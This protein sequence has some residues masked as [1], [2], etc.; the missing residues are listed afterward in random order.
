[1]STERPKAPPGTGNPAGDVSIKERSTVKK[2]RNHKVLM[3]NDDYT[4]QVFVVHV[5]QKFFKKN[6]TEATQ[7]MLTVHHTGVG[8]CGVFPREIA[9]AKAAQVTDY[10]RAH[11]FPL[12]ITS[13]PE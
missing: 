7:I 4:T 2:P 13:E 1:M 8:V 11:G 12:K 5:L 6:E 9:E 10:A 3:H